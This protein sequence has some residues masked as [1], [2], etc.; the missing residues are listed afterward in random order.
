LGPDY[1]LFPAGD[2]FDGLIILEKVAGIE[3]FWRI[4]FRL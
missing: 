4:F 1:K 2:V 3:D